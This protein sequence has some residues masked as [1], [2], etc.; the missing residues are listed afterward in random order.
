MARLDNFRRAFELGE[1]SYPQLRPRLKRKPAREFYDAYK[2]GPV[3]TWLE[4]G[5]IEVLKTAF[6]PIRVCDEIVDE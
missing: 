5:D 1:L 6:P 4:T 3:I 2:L